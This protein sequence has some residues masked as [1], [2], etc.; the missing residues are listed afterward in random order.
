MNHCGSCPYTDG[1][2]YTTMPPKVKCIIT[3]EFHLYNDE[4]DCE[5]QRMLKV[6]KDIKVTIESSEE[7]I[8][9]IN[10][11]CDNMISADDISVSSTEAVIRTDHVSVFAD[12]T[13]C[14]VCGEPIDVNWH[15]TRP[16]MC[17]ECKRAVRFIK[18]KFR[19]E[20]K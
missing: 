8:K 4:C 20:L 12:T 6:V 10:G 17:E 18:E 13:P 9:V 1:C 14:I 3:N 19:E 5:E 15:E 11:T 2:C 16:K 7:D